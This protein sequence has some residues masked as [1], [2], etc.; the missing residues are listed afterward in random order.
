MF[1]AGRPVARPAPARDRPPGPIKIVYATSRTQDALCEIFGPPSTDLSRYA[2]RIE[3]HFWGCRPPG[4]A[5]L[6]ELR[7]MA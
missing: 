2:G 1:R 6:P 7:T 3:A 4:V 5:A